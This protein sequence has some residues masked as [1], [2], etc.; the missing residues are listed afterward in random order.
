ML[1]SFKTFLCRILQ[2]FVSPP[3]QNC[4]CE[5][6]LIKPALGFWL[7]ALVRAVL[8]SCVCLTESTGWLISG[9]NSHKQ[10][11]FSIYFSGHA[12]TL[13]SRQAGRHHTGAHLLK[14]F[15]IYPQN[16]CVS[17]WDPKPARVVKWWPSPVY[18]LHWQ[19]PRNSESLLLFAGEARV[20]PYPLSQAEQRRCLLT[21]DTA[22]WSWTEVQAETHC[23]RT[24]TSTTDLRLCWVCRG[25]R[26]QL[27]RARWP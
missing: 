23:R 14:P 6:W 5:T 25:N 20:H 12:Q 2:G 4:E 7:I 3:L 24:A 16:C 15:C 22:I 8:N 11:Q 18:I 27:K 1:L 13:A 21:N 26:T 17:S 9:N 10:N 19:L